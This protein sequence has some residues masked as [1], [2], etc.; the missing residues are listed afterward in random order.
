MLH[1]VGLIAAADPGTTVGNNLK[2]ILLGFAGAVFLGV[3]AVKGLHLF[4]AGKFGQLAVLLIVA[5]IPGILI[6]N[7][8]GFS[9][10]LKSM[11]NAVMSG[12]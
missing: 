9:H 7:S 6:Y 8:L 10:F 4:G 11:S 3:V 2:N 1:L 12:V 5:L